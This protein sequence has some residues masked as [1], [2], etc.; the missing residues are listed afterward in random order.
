ME[1][2]MIEEM[3][4]N[5]IA[6]QIKAGYKSG[7]TRNGSTWSININYVYSDT[8]QAWIV[9]PAEEIKEL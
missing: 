9:N 1:K 7:I 3:V 8:L 6:E 5:E 2:E 4:D